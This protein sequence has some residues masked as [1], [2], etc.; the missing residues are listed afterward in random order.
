MNELSALTPTHLR[1]LASFATAARYLNFARAA[2]E[3]GCTPSV[4]SRRIAALEA[5]IGGK[6]FLRSTRRVTLTPLGETLLAHCTRLE[7]VVSEVNAEL[8]GQRVEPAGLVRMHLPTTYGRRCVAPLLPELLARYPRLRIDATFDDGYVDLVASRTDLALRIGVPI[9]SGLSA[10]RLRPI[11]R[12]LVAAPSYLADAPP[13]EQPED[14][15]HHRCLAFH[16]LRTGD[17][18]T[19]VRQR[20]K[21]AV[22]VTPVFRANNAD[23]LLEVA[24]AGCGVALLSDFVAADAIAEGKLIEVMTKWPVLQP[25]VQLLWTS[26]AERASRVRVTIDFLRSRLG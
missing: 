4:L 1:E 5:R 3:V 9:D 12:F 18:W 19:F 21:R 25:E 20:Q 14:L 24:Q 7:A 15:K 13:L 6:V 2:R 10:T 16:G 11:R 17:L 26:G 23:A 22:R 8:L